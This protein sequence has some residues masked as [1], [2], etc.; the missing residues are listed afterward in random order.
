MNITTPEQWQAERLQ[1]IGASEAS[2]VIGKKPLDVQCGFVAHQ[3]RP[4]GRRR[5][6]RQGVCA[7]RA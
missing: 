4:Q 6:Q 2:A 7:V 3:N 5:Y 1:G